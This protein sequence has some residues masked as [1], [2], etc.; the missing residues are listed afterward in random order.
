MTETVQV[1]FAAANPCGEEIPDFPDRLRA[2]GIA[3]ED[4]K[5]VMQKCLD[6]EYCKIATL[7]C[8]I[9]SGG[10]GVIFFCIPDVPCDPNRGM[11]EFNKK[12]EPQGIK[13]ERPAIQGWVFN[14]VVPAQ[15]ASQ[16]VV[17]A[18]APVPVQIARDADPAEK[19]AQLKSLLEKELITQADYE[20]KK[21]QILARM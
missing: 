14:F 21:A 2:A 20:E 12:Y 8:T 7:P 10:L 3:E 13:C 4:F 15:A 1:A 9:A 16:A 19:L 17:V 18:T 5:N 11:R 6:A